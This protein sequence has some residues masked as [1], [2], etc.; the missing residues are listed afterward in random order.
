M[1]IAG[2]SASAL[3]SYLLGIETAGMGWE[4]DSARGRAVAEKLAAARN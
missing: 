1:I 3:S 2:E 4:G